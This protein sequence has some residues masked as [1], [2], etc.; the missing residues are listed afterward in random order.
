MMGQQKEQASLFSY[1]ISLEQRIRSDHPLRRV[2]EVVDFSFVREKVAHFYGRNGNESVD[3]AV[4]MKMMFLLFFENIASEREL[5]RVLPERLDY[6]WFLGYQIDDEV[7]DHSVLSKARKRWGKEVFEQFFVRIVA[8][9]VAARLV[10]ADKLH[11][12]SSLIE[13]N[14]SRDSVIKA[15]P[16]L[17]AALKGAY[18][19]TESKLE[20]THTPPG[21]EAVNDTL[22]SCSD[23]DA[24]M[25]RKGGGASR[26]R[27]HHHRGVD[28]AH[29]VITAVETTTG[30]IAENKMLMKLVEQHEANSGA[31][32]STVV[33]D[34]K[35]GTSENYVA[36]QERGIRTHLGDAS[37]RQNNHRCK[38]IFADSEFR[39]DAATDSYVCPAGK[40]LR[41]RRLHPTRRTREY[42]AS[43][44]VCAAC[45]LRSQCTRASYGRTVKRHEHQEWLEV[46]RSQAH[47]ASARRDRRRRQHLME[48][49]FA[50]A[51]NNHGFKRSRWRRLWRQQI[52]DYLIAA[53]QN[54]RIL[55]SKAMPK[56]SKAV[57]LKVIEG[58]LRVGRGKIAPSSAFIA[59][60][61]RFC[62]LL[63]CRWRPASIDDGRKVV[64]FA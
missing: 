32:V 37:G 40:R 4:I 3:P 34:H 57:G 30:S 62:R 64:E 49:S 51:A 54:V 27:Y 8:Q 39:Y 33:G 9:C 13:A 29:G 53:I 22:M 5:M 15:A 26:P 7:P 48:G 63:K 41:P 1:R 2:A 44:G 56:P 43:K 19:A 55:L 58:G 20:E 17:I 11:V 46:A 59:T 18:A 45:P 24:T 31:E 61:R 47:S 28:D 10:G 23:P 12:D 14:A 50:D 6:L 35:Y 42:I 16:E 60:T 25:V 36:C 38:G 52:Q 21:Y